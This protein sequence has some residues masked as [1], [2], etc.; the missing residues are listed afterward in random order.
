[1]WLMLGL[2]AKL[3]G[4]NTLPITDATRAIQFQIT[5]RSIAL[6]PDKWEIEN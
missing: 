1:M 5:L 3:G 6:A 2:L 4:W